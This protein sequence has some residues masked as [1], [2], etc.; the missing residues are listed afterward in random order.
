LKLGYEFEA[1]FVGYFKQ[2]SKAIRQNER[3]TPIFAMMK[4]N[5]ALLLMNQNEKAALEYFDYLT[6]IE[7]QIQSKP[8]GEL[9]VI[10]YKSALGK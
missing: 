6:W 10:N 7:A 5:L 4:N 1:A 8:Y 3:T 9:K 2:L